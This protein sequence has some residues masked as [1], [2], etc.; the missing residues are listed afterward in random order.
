MLAAGALALTPIADR[1]A[2]AGDPGGAL[3]QGGTY[4]AD[5]D[6]AAKL[7]ALAEEFGLEGPAEL[8]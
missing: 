7:Q 2:N 5:L 1:H 6:R 4:N 3:I 8:S